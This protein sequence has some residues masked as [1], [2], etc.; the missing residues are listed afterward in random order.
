MRNRIG[1]EYRNTFGADPEFIVRSP[2]RVNLIGDHTDYNDGYVLPAA[3]DRATWLAAG[4]RTDRTVRL[5]SL[6]RGDA[7]IDLDVLTPTGAWTDYVA[8]TLWAAGLELDRGFNVV[9]GSEIPVGASLSSSAAL[10]IGVARIAY[11]LS[12]T[13]W[14]P[15]AAA[16]AGQRAENG[17]V[18][19]P[20][21]IMDQLIVATGAPGAASLIDCRTLESTPAS[22]PDGVTIVVMDTGTRR[23]LTD[24]AYEDRRAACERV[25]RR[26][27]IPALRDATLDMLDAVELD[28][29]DRQRARH[30]IHENE[31]TVAAAGALNDGD[32]EEAGRLMAASH[33]S[34]RDDYEV[35][36]PALD[37][38]AEIASRH[39][40][41]LGARMTGAGF[42]GCAVGLVESDSVEDFVTS[43]TAAYLRETG[44]DPAFYPT[45][46]SAGA[47]LV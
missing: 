18:G 24:S 20:C 36:G 17:F 27:G 23:E 35:S 15:V 6:E 28:A 22:I 2:G 19:M 12:D 42:A 34:L 29:T 9:L 1:A 5:V 10:E 3:I 43:T 13:S 11:A 14:D 33:R 7:T 40:A 25:A 30:V 4:R 38:M 47:T 31:R 26:L 44:I 39:P 46:P 41:C 16:F 8:G 32:A 21:G 45:V 37:T